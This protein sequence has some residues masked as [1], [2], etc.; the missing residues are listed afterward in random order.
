MIS[1]QAL[2][3]S[4]VLTNSCIASPMSKGARW[5]ASWSDSRRSSSAPRGFGETLR[6]RTGSSPEAFTSLRLASQLSR[7]GESDLGLSFPCV[8][9]D[10]AARQEAVRGL[11]SARTATPGKVSIGVAG[12]CEGSR[13]APPPRPGEAA[14]PP[15]KRLASQ[16]SS[17]GS[18]RF[19]ASLPG[20]WAPAVPPGATSCSPIQ[21]PACLHDHPAAAAI[22][23]CCCE[24]VFTVSTVP[25]PKAYSLGQ[26]SGTMDCSMHITCTAKESMLLG[27]GLCAHIWG[28]LS[29]LIISFFA[30]V[31]ATPHHSRK[32]A[33]LLVG[34]PFNTWKA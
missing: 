33:R 21:R 1:A 14:P 15:P 19:S 25:G 29:I 8:C 16:S 3:S 34:W 18:M 4:L 27:I 30:K 22:R 23:T 13:C 2:R 12:S 5:R 24:T 6:R 7:L 17:S 9:V 28:I 10:I 20:P 11:S 26:N 32:S 31:D